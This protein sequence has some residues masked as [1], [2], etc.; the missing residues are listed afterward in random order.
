MVQSFFRIC[1]TMMHQAREPGLVVMGGD[2]CIKGCEFEFRHCI[3]DG[4]FFIYLLVVKFVM[5]VCLSFAIF[6]KNSDASK[7]ENT[8]KGGQACVTKA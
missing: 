1:I 2:S 3:L 4:H 6:L 5:C 8:E 7:S